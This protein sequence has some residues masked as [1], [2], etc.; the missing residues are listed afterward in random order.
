MRMMRNNILTWLVI[1]AIMG[2]ELPMID[3]YAHF[4]GL[5]TGFLLGKILMDRPPQTADERTRAYT[6]GWAAAIVLV[7]S[8]AAMI[9]LNMHAS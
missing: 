2:Y 3:N 4:G 9:F 1:M 5:A 6:M 7:A 8:V